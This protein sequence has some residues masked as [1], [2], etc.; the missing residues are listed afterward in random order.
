MNASLADVLGAP[1]WVV[2]NRDLHFTRPTVAIEANAPASLDAILHVDDLDVAR[3]PARDERLG[4]A[5]AVRL[6]P[7]GLLQAA[8]DPRS[9]GSGRV[10]SKALV[11][12]AAR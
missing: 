11:D 6:G 12:G 3:I 2:G 1:R 10:Y 7:D 9:D 4:H 5:Q 8:A